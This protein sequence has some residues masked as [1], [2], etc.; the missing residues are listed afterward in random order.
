MH[1]IDG[2]LHIDEYALMIDHLNA[3]PPAPVTAGRGNPSARF[4]SEP[5]LITWLGQQQD[6]PYWRRASL[7]PDYARLTLPA[8]LMGGWYDGYR[9][10]CDGCWP[11]PPGP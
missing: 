1:Y 5:W 2:L 11:Q 6:G 8:F 9:D 4:D 10:W 3:L 7:R